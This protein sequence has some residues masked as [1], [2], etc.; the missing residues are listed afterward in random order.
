[1]QGHPKKTKQVPLS[2]QRSQQVAAQCTQQ[3]ESGQTHSTPSTK[4]QQV[5]KLITSKE[6]IMIQ[7]PDVFEGIGK[8]PGP[9]TQYIRAQAFSLSKDLAAQ[10][11]SI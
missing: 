2:I 7:Y 10:Y 4:K 1:M 8:F 6:Q 9:H 3:M 5:S 11:P